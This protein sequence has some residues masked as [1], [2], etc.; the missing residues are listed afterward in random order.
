MSLATRTALLAVVM[1]LAACSSDPEPPSG[2]VRAVAADRPLDAGPLAAESIPARTAALIEAA[3]L[4]VAAADL[5]RCVV[6]FHGEGGHPAATAP[7]RRRSWLIVAAAQPVDGPVFELRHEVAPELNQVP[8]DDWQD[9]I[10]F[11]TLLRDAD[12]PAGPPACLSCVFDYER[13]RVAY[14]HAYA[15]DTCTATVPGERELAIVLPQ[16]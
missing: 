1:G 4:Q 12:S 15:L 13:G 10:V 9:R 8:D 11:R 3:L 2:S 6:E 5:R 16:G 14:R 7:L